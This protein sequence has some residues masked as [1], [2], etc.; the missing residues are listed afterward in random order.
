M[1]DVE[2]LFMCLFLKSLS[3]ELI[4]LNSDTLVFLMPWTTFKFKIAKPIGFFEGT[5]LHSRE[6]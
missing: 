1:S 6:K 5:Y 4:T 2:H 3:S